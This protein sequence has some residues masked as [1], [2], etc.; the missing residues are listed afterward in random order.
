MNP[1]KFHKGEIALAWGPPSSSY[2]WFLCE[3]RSEAYI[4]RRYPND[5]TYDIYVFG[6]PNI[7]AFGL[8]VGWMSIE[9]YLKKLPPLNDN[10]EI[11]NKKELE[12]C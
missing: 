9:W 6:Y 11:Q 4:E 8:D 12:K 1:S 3:I 2:A 5:W 7:D 10:F